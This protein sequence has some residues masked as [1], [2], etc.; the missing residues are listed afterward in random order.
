MIYLFANA[1]VYHT[2]NK[3]QVNETCR[4][5]LQ[6]HSF[7]LKNHRLWRNTKQQFRLAVVLPN[8]R[9]ELFNRGVSPKPLFLL[10]ETHNVKL[11]EWKEKLVPFNGTDWITITTFIQQSTCNFKIASSENISNGLCGHLML[12]QWRQSM[13]IKYAVD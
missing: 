10:K 1:P 5:Q 12:K 11:I 9:K 13:D 6:V 8:K 7:N 4:Y 3:H 2:S